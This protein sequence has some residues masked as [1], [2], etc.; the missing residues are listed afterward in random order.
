MAITYYAC[1]RGIKAFPKNATRICGILF[2]KQSLILSPKYKKLLSLKNIHDSQ[3][4]FIVCTGPSLTLQDLDKLKGEI[5][6]A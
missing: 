5:C 3:R 2:R 6:L 1:K 4:C